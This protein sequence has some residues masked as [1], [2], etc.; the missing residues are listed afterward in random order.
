MFVHTPAVRDNIINTV[1]F[2]QEIC[3]VTDTDTRDNIHTYRQKRNPRKRTHSQT[4]THAH[5][6]A[7]THNK[8][9]LGNL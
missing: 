9:P 2:N 5:T 8:I 6:Y 4:L 1:G 7:H 3:C